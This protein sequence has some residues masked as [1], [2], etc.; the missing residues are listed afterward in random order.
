M[1]ILATGAAT[2]N[3][4]KFG[5]Y[6]LDAELPAWVTQFDDWVA[7]AIAQSEFNSRPLA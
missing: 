2:H 3:L 6:T 7:E 1:L 4:S 5:G